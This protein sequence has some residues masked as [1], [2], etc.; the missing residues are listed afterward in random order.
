MFS[1]LTNSVYN[2]LDVVSDL[3]D[4]EVDQRKVAKLIADGLT[5]AA[6]ASMFG[7]AEDAIEKLLED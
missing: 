5:V 1:F 7:V 2:A 4:G 3:V 6:V